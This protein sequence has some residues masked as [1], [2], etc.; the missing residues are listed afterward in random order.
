MISKVTGCGK[1][2]GV[3]TDMSINTYRKGCHLLT[4]DD[5]IGSRRVSFILYLPDP[6]KTW[7]PEFG[8]SLRLFP[9]IVPNVPKLISV[10][11]LLHNLIKLHFSP[12]NQVYL[13]M[14]LKKL[15]LI[16]IDYQYKD[17]STFHNLVKMVSFQVN[18]KLLKPDLLYNNYKVK[19]CK[20]LISLNQLEMI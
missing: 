6:D 2:S 15:D 10:L 19:N 9:S 5:V 4:H 16:N 18:K 7:K 8:G 3:K 13:S 12:F 20:N 14:M 17:G 11:N 1:L